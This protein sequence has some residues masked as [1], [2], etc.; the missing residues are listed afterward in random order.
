MALV[1]GEGSERS[2]VSQRGGH[3]IAVAVAVAVAAA[4]ESPRGPLKANVRN[5]SRPADVWLLRIATRSLVDV[6]R[7]LQVTLLCF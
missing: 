6:L 3:N 7:K 1:A 4:A 2:A 5:D